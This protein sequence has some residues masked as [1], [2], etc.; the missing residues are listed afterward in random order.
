MDEQQ[1]P[2]KEEETAAKA[3]PT[4]GAKGFFLDLIKGITLGVSAAVPGLSAGT[5]A[6]AERCYDPL[7]E[8]IDGLRHRFKKSFLFLLPYLLGLLLGAIG[9]LMGI[10][11]GYEV[12]PFTLTGF[13]AGCVLGSL[14]SCL[15]ELRKGKS[16]KEKLIH[17]LAFALSLLFAAGLGA[18][19]ALY[20]FSLGGYLADR[21]WW[22]YPMALLSGLIAAFACVVPGI[23]GS[24]SLMVIGMYYPILNLVFG[25]SSIWHAGD[26]KVLGTGILIL[27]LLLVGAILGLFLASKAM[28]VLLSRHRVSSFYAIFGLILG[29]LD[30]MFFNSDIY[31]KYQAGLP[32]WDYLLGAGLFALSA[33]GVFLLIR[34]SAKRKEKE[35]N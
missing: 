4:R 10:Q 29:S 26:G 23:S 17:I 30:S 16:A 28:N 9:A 22:I 27:L 6:V 1:T 15:I 31:P 8:G 20:S 35:D 13:F 11:K 5:V 21:V 12:A 2:V 7:I 18:L 32:L 34:F 3:A 19:T 24:M 33:L 14:P 25:S